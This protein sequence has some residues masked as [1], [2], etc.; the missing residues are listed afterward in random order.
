VAIQ[1]G[2]LTLVCG[3]TTDLFLIALVNSVAVNMDE[4]ITL[5][6]QVFNSFGSVPEME[7]LDDRKTVCCKF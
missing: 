1:Q 7:L 2:V 3:D 4:Q 5:Q 6:L